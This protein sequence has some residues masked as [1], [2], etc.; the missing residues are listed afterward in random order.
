MLSVPNL[1]IHNLYSLFGLEYNSNRPNMFFFFLSLPI[2]VKPSLVPLVPIFLRPWP[3]IW[4]ILMYAKNWKNVDQQW[5]RNW[6]I[7]IGSKQNNS[8]I[9]VISFV[10]LPHLCQK[11]TILE[12]ALPMV[13]QNSSLSFWDPWNVQNGK[14]HRANFNSNFYFLPPPL[15]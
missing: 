8:E 15:I 6:K 4:L 11:L 10:F 2:E 12:G 7:C 5:K 1:S 14:T 3:W 9:M 13:P